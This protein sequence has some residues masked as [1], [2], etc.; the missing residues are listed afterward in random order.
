MAWTS[1]SMA[2]LTSLSRFCAAFDLATAPV[3][4]R[5]DAARTDDELLLAVLST[6][7]AMGSVLTNLIAARIGVPPAALRERVALLLREKT[8]AFRPGD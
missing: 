6:F 7:G 1:R 5:W 8:E 4:R 2:R 3:S